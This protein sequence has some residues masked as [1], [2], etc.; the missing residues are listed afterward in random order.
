MINKINLEEQV[1][2]FREPFALFVLIGQLISQ[3]ASEFG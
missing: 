3:Y 1:H 2:F